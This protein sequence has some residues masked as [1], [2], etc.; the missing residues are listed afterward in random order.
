[1]EYWARLREQGKRRS[2]SLF[3]VVV[4]GCLLLILAGSVMAQQDHTCQGGHNCNE[5]D[6]G[7]AQGN[8][9]VQ[10]AIVRSNSNSSAHSSS[11]GNSLSADG[12][13]SESSA[14]SSGGASSANSVITID[15]DENE[16]TA[17][18]APNA[19]ASYCQLA[20]SGQGSGGGASIVTPDPVC[21]HLEL[22][23]HSKL[24]WI[25]EM[26][27]CKMLAPECDEGLKHHYYNQYRYHFNE[28]NRIVKQTSLTGQIGM[29]G[30]QLVIPTALIWILFVL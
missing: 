29:T 12:G 6:N 1:M 13:R 3:N 26:E 15:G 30:G 18:S 24:M 22:S 5:E 10:A 25:Q 27:T 11:G 2:S 4:L 21:K 16:Y 19:A 28:A 9:Q 8:T 7:H 17:S 23:N 14:Q 20:G